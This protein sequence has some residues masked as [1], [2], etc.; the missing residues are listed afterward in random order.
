[1]QLKNVIAFLLVMS[2]PS[3]GFAFPRGNS[4]EP[5]SYLNG[6]DR[7]EVEGYTN[8]LKTCHDEG[9]CVGAVLGEHRTEMRVGMYKCIRPRFM[10]CNWWLREG[11]EA[12][13]ANSVTMKM[14]YEYNGTTIPLKFDGQE[15]VT[16][17][18]CA[19]AT[20]DANDSILGLPAYRAFYNRM[21]VQVPTAT[22]NYAGNSYNPSV[23]STRTLAN[24]QV[25]ET[26]AL[27][28]TYG[29]VTGGGY[30]GYGSS[31][32]EVLCGMEKN[33]VSVG[34]YGD[35]IENGF[36]AAWKGLKAAGV[37][38][39]NYSRNLMALT[40]S[41]GQYRES[42]FKYHTHIV[43]AL[44]ANNI[45][46]TSV[47]NFKT[48]AMSF[49]TAAK[50]TG[51]KVY[52]ETIFPRSYWT[53]GCTTSNQVPYNAGYADGGARDQIIAWYYELVEAGTI[54]GVINTAGTV[55]DPTDHTKWATDGVLYSGDCTHPNGTGVTAAS[56]AYKTWGLSL[57]N[58]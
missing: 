43:L 33:S 13:G 15:S 52:A 30:N 16:I 9:A 46:Y 50:A 37:P 24:S 41:I 7:S 45:G 3:I 29:G 2:I 25:Y 18:P 53:P 27:Q 48:Y 22:G 54:N 19:C 4:E 32:L 57:V 39:T 56:A 11:D 34:I 40:P 35:S 10:W 38:A 47:N 26:G 55:Q 23:Y 49:F 17:E 14:A 51:A 42:T 58:Q 21:A 31:P 12:C 8:Q 28:S 44:G 36:S 5:L 20:T 6:T 1:M